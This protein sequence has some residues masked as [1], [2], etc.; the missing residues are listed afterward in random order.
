MRTIAPQVDGKVVVGGE[1]THF[2]ST[3]V[4]YIT[5]LN[6]AT[7]PVFTSAPP[8]S[9]LQYGTAI[10]HTFSAPGFPA[11]WFQLAAG[12]LPPGLTL[13]ASSNTLFGPLIS[14]GT[15]TFT[16][17]ANNGVSPSASQEVT[18][19]VERAATT[20]TITTHTPNPSSIGQTVN[21]YFNVTST[22]GIPAGNVT[23]SDGTVNC[24]GTVVS[25][26]CTIIFNTSGTKTLTAT[27]LGDTNFNTSIS[28]GVS[29]SVDGSGG[30]AL[31]LHLPLVVR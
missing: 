27:Y 3:M 6:G 25:G 7:P 21:V 8:A 1:F 2:N 31:N 24:S 11:P 26:N 5:R 17:T 18:M 10:S 19:E 4:N 28:A 30:G 9:P 13:P 22:A 20:T 16:I 14:A 15:Y 29:H 23:I 12:S